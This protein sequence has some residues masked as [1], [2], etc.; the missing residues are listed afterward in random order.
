[1]LSS[2]GVHAGV[3]QQ[4]PAA[5]RCNRDPTRRRRHRC[6]PASGRALP[7]QEHRAVRAPF[8]T[9]IYLI[10]GNNKYNK[11]RPQWSPGHSTASLFTHLG[12]L[13]WGELHF[14]YRPLFDIF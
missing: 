5:G 1:M 4:W 9:L 14:A 8:P 7:A 3:Q 12:W 13:T 11:W 6:A 2:A 10:Q